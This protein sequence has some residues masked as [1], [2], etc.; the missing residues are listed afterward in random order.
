MFKTIKAKLIGSFAFLIVMIVGLSIYSTSKIFESSD[1]FNQYRHISDNSVLAARIQSNML[2]MRLTVQDYLQTPSA[3][4]QKHFEQK[5]QKISELLKQAHHEITEP[6]RLESIQAIDQDLVDYRKGFN[7]VKTLLSEAQTVVSEGIDH[8]GSLMT[9]Q[10]KSLLLAVEKL[11]ND[12]AAFVA[13]AAMHDL[14]EARLHVAKYIKTQASADA[15][16]AQK[17][18]G[19]FKS[20][21][22]SLSP[23]LQEAG[24]ASV[25][26][27]SDQADHYA[28]TLDHLVKLNEEVGALIQG[29]LD[30]L[31]AHISEMAE[32]VKVSIRDQQSQ[33]GHHISQLNKQIIEFTLGISLVIVLLSIL[34]ATL[35]PRSVARG[36]HAIESRLS[37]ITRTGNFS[38]RA[39]HSRQDE[40]GEMAESVNDM[41]ANTQTAITEANHVVQAIAKGDFAQRVEADL[42]GDL[43]ILKEG[44]NDSAESVAFTMGELRKVMEGLYEG[45]FSVRMDNRVEAAFRDMVDKAMNATSTVISDISRVMDAM[46]E[47]QFDHQVEAE[48][49]G[50]LLQMKNAINGSMVRLKHAMDVIAKVVLA[51][52]EGDLTQACEGDFKGDLKTLSNAMNQSIM[53]LRETVS[54]AVQASNVVSTAASEVSQGATDLSQRVQEQAA[55]LEETSATM[56]EMNSAV[57]SNTQS[58]V[59]AANLASDVRSK[60]HQG[61]EVMRQTIEAMEMIQD[62]SHKIADIVT[63]IDGIAF[64]T[65]LLALNAAVEAA[66]AGEHGRGFAVVAGEVRSLAQKSAEAAKDIKNLI[67]ESVQRINQGTELASES[68]EVLEVINDSID[69][70]TKMVEQIAKA[71]EEQATGVS[72]VHQAI[73]QIDQVTQQNAAL[74]EETTAAAESMSEQAEVLSKDMAYFKTGASVTP[75]ASVKKS[76]VPAVSGQPKPKAAAEPTKEAKTALPQIPAPSQSAKADEED[77]GEF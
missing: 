72:Q 27:L 35:I 17:D 50:E 19:R 1:G 39:D 69:S 40:I 38:L 10:M 23:Y 37:E 45:D 46:N 73:S 68:G 43:A 33:I 41:L 11:H 6:K 21:L 2:E 4:R 30:K 34:I 49:R 60:S 25:N 22:K 54:Q 62:S 7:Q 32:Q 20:D 5:F 76:P 57:Q 52:A 12:Q 14:L 71:S 18:L 13:T 16:L 56:D 64:Q 9:E 3:E 31:G 8:K 51:Q 58:A 53:R 75:T 47:G 29:Q 65:N 28:Q 55:A 70:V 66:R 74:V 24:K 44:V 48:A 77:W 36:L 26:D 15:D 59:E 61:S 42:K 63:L 67:E